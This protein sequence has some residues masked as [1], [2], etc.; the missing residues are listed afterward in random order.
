MSRASKNRF[1]FI[2]HLWPH[3]AGNRIQ[4]K[5]DVNHSSNN[6][7]NTHIE[8]LVWKQKQKNNNTNSCCCLFKAL[9]DWRFGGA[10]DKDNN[11]NLHSNTHHI[12]HLWHLH[13]A[14]VRL[15]SCPAAVFHCI[16]LNL[17]VR[18]LA[19]SKDNSKW[20]VG[21]CQIFAPFSPRLG[22]KCDRRSNR[23]TNDGN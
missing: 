16:S 6:P 8:A 9:M 14:F 17:H 13:S 15:S 3:Q 21:L 10:D 12:Y 23:G 20:R 19:S 5:A 2:S 22:V 1:E 18:R 11:C 4:R 7:L